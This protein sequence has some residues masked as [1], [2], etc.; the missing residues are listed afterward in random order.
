MRSTN[1]AELATK[2][3]LREMEQRMK[4]EFTRID[5]EMRLIKWMLTLLLAGVM[6][7]VFESFFP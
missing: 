7:L 5:G 1:E 6:S 3:D 4:N 2:G